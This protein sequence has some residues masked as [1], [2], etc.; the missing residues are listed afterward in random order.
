MGESRTPRPEPFI[1][2]HYERIRWFV[3]NPSDA[4]RQAPG[5]SSHV[6]LDRACPGLRDAHPVRSPAE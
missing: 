6:S 1:G 5:R 3:V 4:H 2:T